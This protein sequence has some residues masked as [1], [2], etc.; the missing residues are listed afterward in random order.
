MQPSQYLHQE[1]MF[2]MEQTQMERPNL[3]KKKKTEEG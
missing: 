3:Q 2:S 1:D